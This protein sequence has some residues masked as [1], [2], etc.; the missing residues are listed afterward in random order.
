MRRLKK[1]KKVKKLKSDYIQITKENKKAKKESCEDFFEKGQQF[2]EKA[3]E[4]D[5]KAK[6]LYK[7]SKEYSKKALECYND[8]ECNFEQ[9]MKKCDELLDVCDK[10]LNNNK[11]KTYTNSDYIYPQDCNFN[12]IEKNNIEPKLK[13]Y[14]YVDDNN[15]DFADD[16]FLEIIYV[17]SGLQTKTLPK[18]EKNDIKNQK[19]SSPKYVKV[20]EEKSKQND[21]FNKDF[22]K[23]WQD[24]CKMMN[25]IFKK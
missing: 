13:N 16:G 9:K 19:K 1:R 15:K 25:E 14:Y 22:S 20:T 21:S 3:N 17:N 8:A 7:K 12:L 23:M 6:E 11:Q 24:Y 2:L 10:K 4:Y 18:P 5:K